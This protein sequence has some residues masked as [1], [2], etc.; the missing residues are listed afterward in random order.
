VRKPNAL[1]RY[2]AG[3]EV[4]LALMSWVGKSRIPATSIRLSDGTQLT[5]GAPADTEFLKVDGSQIVGDPGGGGGGDS[6]T[7]NATAATDAQFGSSPAAPANAQ[8]VVFQINT[9]TSPDQVSAYL[10]L[11]GTTIESSGGA[12][13]LKDGAVSLAK[14]ANIATSTI[15]G[16]VTAGTG[17]P[18]ALTGDQARAIVGA[19]KVTHGTY[20][21][22][23]ASPSNGDVHFVTGTPYYLSREGGAWVA[24]SRSHGTQLYLPGQNS[25][26]AASWTA[27]TGAAAGSASL[28][29]YEQ[30]LDL[31]MVTPGGTSDT[32]PF[33]LAMSPAWASWTSLTVAFECSDQFSNFTKY[34][35]CL[36]ESATGKLLWFGPHSSTGVRMM[37]QRQ[38]VP[39]T[40][41]T[42]IGNDV[43]SGEGPLRWYR[44]AK[45][46][47][48]IEFYRSI[49]GVGWDSY[50]S[51]A[52]GTAFTTNP[53]RIALLI[54][55][56]VASRTVRMRVWSVQQA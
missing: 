44:L 49:D 2:A 17:A 50:G 54:M 31:S 53:N 16:R 20:A 11:D 34:A 45:N 8:N 6:V 42:T 28:T 23:P 29:D 14:M 52:V 51:I 55:S 7:V 47:T 36:R 56:S 10:L 13:R 37:S 38:T 1:D 19:G 4:A 12:L 32:F 48:N 27:I 3:V 22:A 24:R 43:A 35:A 15:L 26:A 41:I 25:M 46:G 40:A 33:D 5:F 39:G 30:G 21:G 18:E 9:A